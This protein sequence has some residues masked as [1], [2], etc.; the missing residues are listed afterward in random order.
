MGAKYTFLYISDPFRSV[1]FLPHHGIDRFLAEGTMG[2]VS[3]NS[4]GCDEVCQIKS[5]LLEGFLVVSRLNLAYYKSLEKV[6][7]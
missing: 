2:N 1:E 7:Y 5:S 4:T 6:G 3:T